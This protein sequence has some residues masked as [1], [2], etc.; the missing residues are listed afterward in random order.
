MGKSQREKGKRGERRIVRLLQARGVPAVRS[1]AMQAGDAAHAPDVTC[2][3]YWIESKF[4]KAP[5]IRAALKQAASDC[6]EDFIPVA[7]TKR[8]GERAIA[9]L[10]E[11]DFAELLACLFYQREFRGWSWDGNR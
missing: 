9:S 1:A 2:G 6:S 10:Y 8:D 7:V 11:D 5:S 4:G 3:P